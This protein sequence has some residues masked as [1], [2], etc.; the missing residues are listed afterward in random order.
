[1]HLTPKFAMNFMDKL[2]LQIDSPITLVQK[3][4]SS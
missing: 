4:K 2:K 1:M 3:Q